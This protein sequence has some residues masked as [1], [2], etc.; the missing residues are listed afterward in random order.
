MQVSE[1]GPTTMSGGRSARKK[2]SFVHLRVTP[3]YPRQ[4][5][6]KT[7]LLDYLDKM[8]CNGLL[9]VPWGVFD[10]P[11]LAT[12][13]LAEPDERYAESLRSNPQHWRAE[14]WTSVYDFTPGNLKKVERN[15]DW[16][17]GEFLGSPDPKEGYSLK[18]LR[19]PDARLVIGFLNPI[20]HPEKPKRIV[21]KWAS[22]FLGAM[23]GKCKVAWN[24]LMAD[25]VRRLVSELKKGKKGGSPL[26]VYLSH[27]YSKYQV[28]T[29]EE[30]SDYN[31]QVQLLEYGGMETDEDAESGE[32][33]SPP[34]RDPRKRGRTEE[35]PTRP[36]V[37]VTPRPAPEVKGDPEASGSGRRV[38]GPPEPVEL[39][40]NV[41]EDILDLLRHAAARS[42]YQTQEYGKMIHYL[43]D[44]HKELGQDDATATISRIRE[45]R[46][47]EVNLQVLREQQTTLNATVRRM[48]EQTDLARREC[49]AA[50]LRA[51]DSA[52]ALADVRDA[53]N[54]PVDIV[55]RGL[56]F[57]NF[58]EKDG[59]INRAQIIRFLM[60][61][62]QRMESTW[63]KMQVLVSNMR[64]RDGQQ[65]E[66]VTP[67]KQTTPDIF[68]TPEHG[69]PSQPKS[70]GDASPDDRVSTPD[71][72]S[73][74]QVDNFPKVLA[75]ILSPIKAPA[76]EVGGPSGAHSPSPTRRKL[77]DP[78][79]R[80]IKRTPSP[81][82]SPSLRMPD[83]GES[84]EAS[85]VGSE[86]M[87]DE[88]VPSFARRR[89]K[90]VATPS[91]GES[92]RSL[93]EESPL[94]RSLRNKGKK[95]TP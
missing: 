33:S 81:E 14:F 29:D 64:G 22:T 72:I 9:A 18:D 40:G 17:E 1:A 84:E 4:L 20:F 38:V 58:L 53:L 69:G 11:Q 21:I 15:D 80:G 31:V 61:H 66:T 43:L 8:G 60:D 95:P 83:S 35:T 55:N 76:P 39:T 77:T 28:L 93:V 75:D 74:L 24:E 36:T 65:T 19:D 49:A 67:P 73:P 90:E 44:I 51:E 2:A 82:A 16:M 71:F 50:E 37:S 78:L 63:D 89:S 54:F 7:V 42:A 85:P 94:R 32:Q 62:A 41:A 91:P 10:H 70:R 79:S 26:P 46:Q 57:T 5:R 56:L 88:L 52:R 12:E 86:A 87:D 25:L 92:G 45:L 30:Q 59:K 68:K 6:E 34:L 27:L 23:R 48:K 3:E 13:L 47:N